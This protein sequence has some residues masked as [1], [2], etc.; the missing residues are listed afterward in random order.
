MSQPPQR[1]QRPVAPMRPDY[2]ADATGLN[3]L[4]VDP[5]AVDDLAALAASVAAPNATRPTTL[6]VTKRT[7]RSGSINVRQTLIPLMLTGGAICIGL[8]LA[9]MMTDVD[10]P[11]RRVSAILP[12]V[13]AVTGVILLFAALF[14]MLMVKRELQ[15]SA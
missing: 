7:P 1:P 12:I 3:S 8:A 11:Y 10:S 15:R 4:P 5:D 9:W 13:L 2:S 14:N 6:T